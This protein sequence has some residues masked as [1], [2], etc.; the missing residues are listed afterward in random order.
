MSS[1][2]PHSDNGYEA[3]AGDS[4]GKVAAK[5]GRI[6][7]LKQRVLGCRRRL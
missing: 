7:Q 1:V 4:S 5:G 2:P 3:A 6:R